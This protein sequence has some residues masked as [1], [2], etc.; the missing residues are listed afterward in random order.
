MLITSGRATCAQSF[1]A[2]HQK[3]YE[4]IERSDK[5]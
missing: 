5:G 1:L 2:S 3:K 4:G